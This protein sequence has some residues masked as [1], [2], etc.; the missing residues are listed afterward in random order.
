M[1]VHLKGKLDVA[2]PCSWFSRA[3][4]WP[5]TPLLLLV[6]GLRSSW[7]S[8]ATDPLTWTPVQVASFVRIQLGDPQVVFVSAARLSIMALIVEVSN[9][10]ISF[11]N[12]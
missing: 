10:P 1:V 4:P 9:R 12:V 3:L 8:P 6:G 5:Q 11:R 2:F 7:G